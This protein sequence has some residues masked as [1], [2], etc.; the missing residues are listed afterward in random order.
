MHKQLLSI[1]GVSALSLVAQAHAMALA[2]EIAGTYL[3]GDGANSQWVQVYASASDG[4]RGATYGGESW[5]TGIWGLADA[6]QVLSLSMGEP[7]VLK[8]F[9][10]VANQISFANQAY[11]DQY[12]ATWST[13]N[14]APIFTNGPGENQENFAAHFTGYI[15]ITNA[16]LYNFGVLYDDGFNFTLTGAGGASVSISQDGL[17]PRNRLGFGE[18]LALDSGLYAFDL[19]AYNR[20]EVGVVNLSWTQNGGDWIT[21]N[22][23]HLFTYAVPEPGD[24]PLM[25]AGLVGIGLAAC[26]KRRL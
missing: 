11:L 7:H 2:P 23:D 24:L 6:H 3:N 21:V 25:L 17:N 5:G 20:L 14:L 13:Q 12:A 4:W 16:G 22:Q 15:S 19:L 10:G 26:R 8:T 9:S 18:D 1:L